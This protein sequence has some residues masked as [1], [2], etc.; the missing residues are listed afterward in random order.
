MFEAT[1]PGSKSKR[2]PMRLSP[3]GQLPPLAAASCE[4]ISDG[5][6]LATLFFR[7]TDRLTLFRDC[8]PRWFVLDLTA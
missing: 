8:Q 6:R 7:V 5:P 1:G 2:C 4:L 3:S